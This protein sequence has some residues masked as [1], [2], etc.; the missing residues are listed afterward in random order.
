MKNYDYRKIKNSV[1]RLVHLACVSKKNKFQSRTWECHILPVVEHSLRLGKLLKADLEV[2][3][4]AAY[5]HDIA[6]ITNANYVKRHHT[7]GAQMAKKILRELNYPED[8]IKKVTRCILTHRGSVKTRR[9][10]LEA[11]ILASAD[12]MSHFS[13]LV[14]MF[15]LAFKIHDYTTQEGVPWLKGK[16][17]RS[18]QKIIP[19]GRKLIKKDY[20]IAM[21]LLNQA[22]KN[23]L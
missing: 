7:Y 11:K 22:I 9:D 1:I 23:D 10:T 4:L 3:E 2:L 14:E 19:A 20:K 8:K 13:E 15:Y 12:A 17:E 5:L 6:S 18:W 21:Y 16:L